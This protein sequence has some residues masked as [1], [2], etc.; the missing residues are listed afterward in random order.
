[1]PCTWTV[2]IPY[3]H[4][5]KAEESFVPSPEDTITAI[6]PQPAAFSFVYLPGIIETE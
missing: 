4:I 2:E 6:R 1:M 5:L 3:F